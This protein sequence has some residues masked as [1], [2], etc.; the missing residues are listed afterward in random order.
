MGRWRWIEWTQEPG[1][2]KKERRTW[3][4]TLV[5]LTAPVGLGLGMVMQSEK[6]DNAEW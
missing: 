5:P 1:E 6:Q 2:R 3:P 4:L